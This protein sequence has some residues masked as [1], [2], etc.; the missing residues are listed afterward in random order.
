MIR[1]LLDTLDP[2]VRILAALVFAVVAVSLH[3]PEALSAALGLALALALAGRLPLGGTLKRLAAMD[4][5]ILLALASL[6]FTVAGEEVFRLGEWPASREGLERAAVI[7]LKTNAAVLAVLALVA[8][9]DPSAL[10]R[11]LKHLRL[12]DGLIH[13][14]LLTTRYLDVLEQEYRRLRQAMRARG[15]RPRNDRHG[16]RSLGYLVGML[17]VRGI[18]RSERVL[19]AM[20]CRG[21][22]GRLHLL[23]DMACGRA[24]GVFLAL[25]GAGLILLAALELP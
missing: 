11:A 19:A 21:F 17:L 23:G 5:F 9:L 1:S 10:A 13:L 15:F 20:K 2:R 25:S 16:W 22:D 12:P 4:G 14:L 8:P 6:P 24:D 7:A 18:E 3:R